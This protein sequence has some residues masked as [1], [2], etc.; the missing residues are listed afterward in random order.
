MNVKF[1]IQLRPQRLAIL[2]VENV[3]KTWYNILPSELYI[4][5]G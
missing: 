2:D 4:Y 3:R 5:L 1:L